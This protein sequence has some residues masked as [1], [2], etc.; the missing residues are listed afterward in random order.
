MDVINTVRWIRITKDPLVL[1]CI[2]PLRLRA[3]ARDFF[4]VIRGHLYLSPRTALEAFE[5]IAP[6]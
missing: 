5:Q 3:S 4:F 1:N 2:F 6:Y